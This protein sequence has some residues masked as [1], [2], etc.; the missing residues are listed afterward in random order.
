MTSLLRRAPTTRDAY[1]ILLF[2]M[3]TWASAFPGL[4]VA[5]QELDP[6]SLTTWR[7]I[8][9]ALAL[10]LSGIALKTP[11]PRWRDMPMILGMGL[12]GFTVYH[13]MLNYG[14]QSITAGQGSFIIAT[15]PIWTTLMAAKFLG[16][17]LS[18]RTWIG[19]LLGLSGVAYMSLD[20]G[21]LTVS[22][23]VL[24]V[25]LAAICSGGAMVLQKRL[26]E[27]YRALDVS[28][29][30]TVMGVLPLLLFVPASLPAVGEM[31]ARGWLVV[32]YL[33]VVP[34]ALGFYL[35]NVALRV[36]PAGRTAQMLLLVPPMSAVIAW[37]IIHET[38]GMKLLIGGPLILGGVLLGN[39]QRRADREGVG[40]SRRPRIVAHAQRPGRMAALR[41]R[42]GVAARLGRP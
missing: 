37:L 6:I 40:R 15:I 20:P 10:L 8:F 9:A 13:L 28:V 21:K 36:L 35:S 1:L 38:P 19:L 29:Y 7:M 2:T 4:R 30:A 23:G 14:M 27:R 18:L 32:A 22:S 39:L 11:L 31:S 34:I 5:L 25:L 24:I 17:R 26:L 42:L 3:A 16:E 33:G 12:M 41:R